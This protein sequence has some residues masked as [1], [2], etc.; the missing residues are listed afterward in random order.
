[1]RWTEPDVKTA[2]GYFPAD[3]LLDLVIGN[4]GTLGIITRARVRLTELPRE[5]LG[6][7]AFLPSRQVATQVVRAARDAARANPQGGVSPRCIEYL[8]ARC[9]EFVRERVGEVPEQAQAA[10]CCSACSGPCGEPHACRS[11]CCLPLRPPARLRPQ[12]QAPGLCRLLRS[13][14]R[15]LGRPARA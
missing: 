2:A 1:M 7:L 8:D 15:P 12:G 9:L 4:E 14:Y 13:F 3:N 10:L 6:I 11:V 5:V